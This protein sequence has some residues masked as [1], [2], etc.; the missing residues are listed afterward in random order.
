M[1][2][3]DQVEIRQSGELSLTDIVAIGFL[4]LMGAAIFFSMQWH[5][6]KSEEALMRYVILADQSKT[7]QY[8]VP[9]YRQCLKQRN[10]PNP[11]AC[12]GAVAN[13]AE[14]DG[15]KKAEIKKV[16][17]DIQRVDEQNR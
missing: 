8:I 1:S 11:I 3:L 14:M 12:K 4:L 17:I 6:Y 16:F 9:A 5:A 10:G 13:A 15:Y 2:N 7:H